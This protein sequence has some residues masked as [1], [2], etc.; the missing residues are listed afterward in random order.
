MNYL[1]PE[2]DSA[3]ANSL[4]MLGLAHLGD[5]VYELM[6]RTMLC[7]NGHSLS[8]DL[9][10]QT[11][12]LVNARAQAKAVSK[13]LPALDEEESAVFKRG[14]N[15]HVNSVPQKAQ[16]SEYHAATGLEALF[17]WLFLQGRT[18]RLN[19]LFAIIHE[20]EE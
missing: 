13:I 3:K 15:S 17:G 14:R 20:G 10:Q 16:V 11:V 19:E 1:K 8:N 12:K 2:L 18:E 9:H 7:V 6:T 4:S 5:A